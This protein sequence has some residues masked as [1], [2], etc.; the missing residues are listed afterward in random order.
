[1]PRLTHVVTCDAKAG[2]SSNRPAS[3][4]STR[5]PPFSAREAPHRRRAE[6]HHSRKRGDPEA[7]RTIVLD[8]TYDGGGLGKQAEIERMRANTALSE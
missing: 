2:R 5:P 4:L 1:M 7:G 3:S 8:F 6:E